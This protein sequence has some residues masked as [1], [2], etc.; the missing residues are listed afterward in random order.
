MG[1]A[2]TSVS[3]DCWYRELKIST[4]SSKSMLE[5]AA[6]ALNLQDYQTA[7]ELITILLQQQPE[8][9]RVQLYAA[10][11]YA[12]TDRL[13]EAI[14][15]YRLL[16]QRSID[17]KIT[18]AARQGI[19]R[20]EQI[21]S[22]LHAQALAVA[23]AQSDALGLL[24][25]EPLL[26][27]HKQLAIAQFAKIMDIDPYS[28]RLKLPTRGWRLY[29]LGKI[30]E[31]NFYRERLQQAEIPSFCVAQQDTQR[32][33]VFRVNYFQAFN[34]QA[35]IVCTD[36]RAELRTFNFKWSEITQI[37]M[38]VLPIFEEVVEIY[39]GNQTRRKRKILD[40]IHICDL[41][42]RDRRSI[43]RLSSQTYDF[44][45]FKQLI[46]Q[47]R[48]QLSGALSSQLTGALSN[49]LTGNFSGALTGDL[50]GLLNGERIPATSRDN[51]Q[52]LMSQIR[53]RVSRVPIQNEFTLF[54]ETALGFPELLTH[55]DPHLNLLRR[56][57][58]NWDRAFQLYSTLSMCK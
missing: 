57:D 29:K 10:Q 43:F 42:L 38:G 41:Q 16:L 31:L 24:I 3:T 49:Q 4:H 19:E 8:N 30:G 11:L 15:T 54:A 14:Q 18:S 22:E 27:E 58:S 13:D 20:V 33:Y 28:A 53:D 56:A 40:Y 21:Q 23:K 46:T 52:K 47:S 32:F 50:S 55:I 17:P 12:A 36:D 2:N 35:S 51:W 45:D 9:D 34:P 1:N 39:A 25:L 7:A 44:C 5:Q 6:N 48:R 37:V 26:P